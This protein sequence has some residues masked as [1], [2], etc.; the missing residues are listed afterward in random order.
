MK[1]IEKQVLVQAPAD[2]VYQVWRNFENFP[3]LMDHVKEVTVTGDRRTHWRVDGP[4]GFSAEWDAE[5]TVDEPARAVAWESVEGSPVRTQGRVDFDGAG[6]TT[7]IRLALEYEA[8]GGTAGGIVAKIFSNPDK[9]V[10]DD[11]MRFKE[12]MEEG[13]QFAFPGAGKL[14]RDEGVDPT[15]TPVGADAARQIEEH[16]PAEGGAEMLERMEEKDR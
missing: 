14:A 1:R 12:K 11:L 3:S 16:R 2:T 10:E 5:Q 6:G 7:T 8:P 15:G 9:Q 13:Q 4:L